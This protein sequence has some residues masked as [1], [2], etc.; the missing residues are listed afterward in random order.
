LR[1][2]S[3]SNVTSSLRRAQ[4]ARALLAE[5]PGAQVEERIG[6]ELP[7][8]GAVAALHVVGVDLELGLG[9]HLRLRA[10]Q[11]VRVRLGRIRLLRIRPHDHPPPEHTPRAAAEHALVELVAGAVGNRVVDSGVVVYELLAAADEQAVQRA[12][13]AFVRQ[14]HRGVVAH[15]RSTE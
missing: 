14:Q 6:V 8:A 11:Q 2:R 15:D 5:P 9:V 1:A 12:L 10:Q 4:V 7:D 13:G 3:A